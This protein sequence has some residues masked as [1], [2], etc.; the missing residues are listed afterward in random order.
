MKAVKTEKLL[1]VSNVEVSS[2][3]AERVSLGCEHERARYHIWIDPSTLDI[4]DVLYKNPLEGTD[5]NS[6][7]YFRTRKMRVDSK[8]SASL[9]QSMLRQMKDGDLLAKFEDWEAREE[10][11]RKADNK[12]AE[13]VRRM[14]D[15][16]EEMYTE[17]VEIGKGL[18]GK[19]PNERTSWEKNHLEFIG[20]IIKKIG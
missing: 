18:L 8:F 14:K 2:R 15:A 9:I 13:R 3:N 17:I 12:A 16:A 6:P 20:K 7:E 4:E 10:T 11:K 1:V 5:R 19:H